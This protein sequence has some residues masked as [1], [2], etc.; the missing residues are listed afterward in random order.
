MLL[1]GCTLVL[2]TITQIILA[3]ILKANHNSIKINIVRRIFKEK[4]V[5]DVK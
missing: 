1:G 2:E 5:E 3:E 4:N